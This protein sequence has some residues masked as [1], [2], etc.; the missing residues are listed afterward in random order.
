MVP[1]QICPCIFIFTYYACDLH[2]GPLVTAAG[3]LPE[4]PGSHSSSGPHH[5]PLLW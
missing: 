4:V 1:L 5:R 3:L 2:Y